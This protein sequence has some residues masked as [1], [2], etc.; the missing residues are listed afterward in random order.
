MR[1]KVMQITRTR[2]I[3]AALATVVANLAPP[4]A[5]THAQHG[6]VEM[7]PWLNPALP[8]DVRADLVLQAMTL[9]EKIRLVHGHVG[10][11]WQG[12][13]KPDGAIGSAGYVPGIARLGLP[14]LQESDAGLG[15]ANP[16]N[17][18][19]D[20]QATPLPSGLAI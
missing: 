16:G 13:P 14:A 12:K 11:P 15:V 17:V 10:M 19:P 7:R 18:R 3:V 6:A 8:P 2:S 1:G 5:S 9:D 20:D 4:P